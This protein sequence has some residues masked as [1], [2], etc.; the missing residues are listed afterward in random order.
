MYKKKL[1]TGIANDHA[2]FALKLKIVAYFVQK[3]YEI[4]DFGSHTSESVDYPDYA[5]TL[6]KAVSDGECDFGISI[7]CTG[8]GINMAVNKHEAIRGALCWN[9]EISVLARAHNDAN[10]CSLPADFISE[11]VAYE[12][13]DKF[14]NTQFENGRHKRRVEKIK[15]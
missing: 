3:G 5:H 12:I 6:A 9:S 13:I 4:K 11:E 10:V 14:L 1:I 15:C 2:G 7:C 8:N